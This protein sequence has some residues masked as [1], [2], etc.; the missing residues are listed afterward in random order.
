MTEFCCQTCGYKTTHKND[1]RRHLESKRHLDR[2][3]GND[4]IYK[5]CSEKDHPNSSNN[6]YQCNHCKNVFSKKS[7]LTR[8]IS[9]CSES[10]GKM[11]ELEKENKQLMQQLAE[12][13]KRHKEE[14]KKNAKQLELFQQ[15]VQSSTTLKKAS[16][17][18]TYIS[19]TFMDAPPLLALDD[20]SGVNDSEEM[21][22]VEVII[23]QYKNGNLGKFLAE[24]IVKM[25]KKDDPAQQSLWNSDTSR[26]TYIVK[27]LLKNKKS[28][29]SVDKKGLKTKE[30]I[31]VP[32]LKYLKPKIQ[33]Y[34]LEITK[35]INDCHTNELLQNHKNAHTAALLLQ[36]ISNGELANDI[37][38]RIAPHFYLNKKVKDNLLTFEE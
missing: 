10:V 32:L 27:E 11:Q 15:L 20:Y 1:M 6:M 35:N 8:H 33:S 28:D 23:L 29:W 16:S 3:S 25:Y 21:S 30:Y 5:L 13:R 34:M 2:V 31:I 37:V 22:L 36:E 14:E 7:N 24:F 9:K 38:K 18:I 4:I 26:L 12:E 19:N 17:S